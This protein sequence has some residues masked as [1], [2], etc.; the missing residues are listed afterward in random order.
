MAG[1]EIWA[2]SYRCA[3][4]HPPPRPQCGPRP[5]FGERARPSPSP[6]QPHS[7]TCIP[8]RR[9]LPRPSPSCTPEFRPD[10]PLPRLRPPTT[11]SCRSAHPI[12]APCAHLHTHAHLPPTHASTASRVPQASPRP[13]LSSISASPWSTTIKIGSMIASSSRRARGCA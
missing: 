9:C 10:H 3:C 11:S 12:P 13:S 7:L 8:R 6:S 5:D 4:Q 1:S 2:A